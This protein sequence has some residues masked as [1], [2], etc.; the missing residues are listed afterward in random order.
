MRTGLMLRPGN[1]PAVPG[2][3]RTHADFDNLP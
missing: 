3:H 1:A 2:P